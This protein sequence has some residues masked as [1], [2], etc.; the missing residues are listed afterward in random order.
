MQKYHTGF[1][2]VEVLTVILILALSWLWLTPTWQQFN[3]QL[4]LYIEQWRLK[5]YLAQVQQRANTSMGSWGLRVSVS[6]DRRRWC[7]L[8]QQEKGNSTPCD[9]FHLATCN[10]ANNLVYFPYSSNNISFHTKYTYPQPLTVFNSTRNTMRN[11]CFILQLQN[12]NQ[13]QKIVFKYSGFG[14]VKVDDQETTS[15]CLSYAS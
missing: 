9:C 6:P 13:P 12:S 15:A 8:A 4:K 10:Q 14:E 11:S 1:T 5:Q 3:S 7:L 2:L